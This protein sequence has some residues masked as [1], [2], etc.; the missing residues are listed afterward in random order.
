MSLNGSNNQIGDEDCS[1]LHVSGRGRIRPC[2]Q[3]ILSVDHLLNARHQ[4]AA[5]V[6]TAIAGDD[7]PVP[8]HALVGLAR[9]DASVG[10][11]GIAAADPAAIEGLF[12]P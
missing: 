8:L 3:S 6:P 2:F 4:R 7:G 10:A 12:S 1:D 11:P 5:Q 9:L